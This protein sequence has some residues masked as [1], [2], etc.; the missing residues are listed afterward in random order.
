[1]SRIL[2][3]VAK[4]DITPSP[5]GTP[6]DGY[7][8][9]K[10]GVG[11]SEGVHDRLH[12]RA[13]VLSDGRE[14]IAIVA[15]DLIGVDLELT[16][17]IRESVEGEAGIVGKNV[18]IAAS[19]THS[20]PAFG[21]LDEV[22]PIPDTYR[23]DVED[24]RQTLE[25]KITSAIWIAN[26]N[27]RKAK[28]GAGKGKIFTI[29]ANRNDPTGSVDPEVGVLRVDDEKG[30]LM[31]V[32]VNYAC[33]P[34]VM[35]ADNLLISADFTGYAMNLIE[36]KGGR[37]VVAL[38]TNGAAGDISTRFTRHE[39][40]FGEVK[41][42]GTI[43]GVETLKVLEQIDTIDRLRLRSAVEEVH[44]PFRK[45]PT[46]EEAMKMVEDS[47]K[48]LAELRK[49]GAAQPEIRVAETT[50]QGA[51]GTLRL[52]KESKEKEIITEVQAIG[53]N[54][55]TLIG[56]PGELLVEIGLDIKKKSG[57]KHVYI[58]SM[59]N[60]YVGYIVTRKAYEEGLYEPLIT[61]LS[62]A[63]GKIILDTALKLVVKTRPIR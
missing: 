29:G 61:R 35:G 10:D 6:L 18:L 46:L 15:A 8:A 31:G 58:V 56:V 2:A 45:L 47:R 5:V 3:G 11:P 19:H 37:G 27:L 30:D 4:V 14:K 63:G 52:V 26:K 22:I 53:I 43:L 23:E 54:D 41:R 24:Y 50:L 34:T 40:T 12:A 20:G 44:L 36:K 16:K 1:M 33:H 59:A 13:L 42:F 28:V 51:I 48:T 7:A 32:L 39:Q 49:K 21:V 9:R 57:L 55:I 25:R 62:P 38:F 17:S 60:D